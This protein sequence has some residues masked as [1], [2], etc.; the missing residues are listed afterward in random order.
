MTGAG[1]AEARDHFMR[2]A[3][4]SAASPGG[5]LFRGR[6]AALAAIHEWLTAE[7]S[8][9]RPL[10]VIGSRERASWL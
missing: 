1:Q 2:R 3:R 7:D 6:Q 10:V 5:D 9:G 4:G 8:P